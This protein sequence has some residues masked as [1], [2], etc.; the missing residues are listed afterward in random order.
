[1]DKETQKKLLKVVAANY[2]DIGQQ[3]NETRKKPLW[4]SLSGVL[5]LVPRGASVLD[6][7]CG[8][9]RLRQGVRPQPLVALQ[10]QRGLPW[11][12]V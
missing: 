3:F 11:R 6:V 7:G 4:P 9:V 2:Q 10:Q 1:M 5:E 12:L 8:N